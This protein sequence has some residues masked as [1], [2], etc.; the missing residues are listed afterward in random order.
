MSGDLKLLG[1]RVDALT[2]AYR[3]DLDPAFVDHLEARAKVAKKHGRA[4]FV[5]S[6]AVPDD[7]GDGVAMSRN[8][9][10]GVRKVL[11]HGRHRVGPMPLR[12][13][14][15]HDRIAREAKTWGELRFSR[16]EGCWRIIN[17]G[18]AR[19][20]VTLNAPGAADK[21]GHRRMRKCSR[22]AGEGMIAIPLVGAAFV[23][24]MG[25]EACPVCRGAGKIKAPG[26]TLEVTWYAQTLALLGLEK[27]IHESAALAANCGEVLETR[28]RR[29][30][31]CADVGGWELEEDLLRQLVKRPHAEWR[32]WNQT[33]DDEK[34]EAYDDRLVVPRARRVSDDAGDGDDED[35]AAV[36][37]AGSLARRRVTG[38]VIGRGHF[39]C[40][41]YDKRAELARA[42]E[43]ASGAERREL[44]EDRWRRREWDG[45]SPVTRVEF[46]LRGEALTEL[47][48]RDPDAVTMP[49]LRSVPYVDARGKPR[50]RV[51]AVG[52]RVLEVHEGGRARQ[53]TVVDRLNDLWR[54]CL[55]WVRLVNVP[56][57]KADK[58]PA[59]RLEDDPRWALLREAHFTDVVTGRPVV[60]MRPRAAASSA[61][62][63]GVALSQA[64]RDGRIERDLSETR[65]DYTE[66]AATRARLAARVRRLFVRAAE[67]CVDDMIHKHGG[68]VGAAV[69]FAVRQNSSRARFHRGVWD[70]DE[71][72]VGPP[73]ERLAG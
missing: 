44:E 32:R 24:S 22:C 7:D 72:A 23:S 14:S 54:T 2:V 53:M 9:H 57:D 62:G 51:V 35:R 65:A 36:Y 17:E 73:A 56:R 30:D 6:V 27:T 37:G 25:H 43:H 58:T 63:L 1:W 29:L 52:T 28:I 55:A 70:D 33:D 42:A 20:G 39:L 13:A 5:W 68:I 18:Y 12:W 60:R 10:P 3:V 46:Q 64:A 47:G 69:H 26:W 67:R 50:V 16:S 31:L 45:I 40:R 8:K 21:D 59:I 19:I 49:D 11:P 34:R 38:F 15:E 4:A 41:I 61:Q 48:I 66:D 71:Q